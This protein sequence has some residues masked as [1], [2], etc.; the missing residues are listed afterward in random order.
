MT[1]ELNT[2]VSTA[3]NG[4]SFNAARF[5]ST[6]SNRTKSLA[7]YLN[8]RRVAG[9]SGTQEQIR[10]EALDS[11]VV[12]ATRKGVDATSVKLFKAALAMPQAYISEVMQESKGADLEAV[13]NQAAK[14][15]LGDM[16]RKVALEAA[17]F[18]VDWKE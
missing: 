8:V 11:L 15:I 9:L 13:D 17:G 10:Q 1:N 3:S 12:I 2:T 16:S 4:F 14:T 18:T 6:A 5:D 7:D